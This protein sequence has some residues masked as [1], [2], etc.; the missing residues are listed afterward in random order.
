MNDVFLDLVVVLGPEA[1]IR[2]D[3]VG[4]SLPMARVQFLLEGMDS[5]R[6][7]STSPGALYA[8]AS[9]F[10]VAAGRL[11]RIQDQRAS[12]TGVP[13]PVADVLG[14]AETMSAEGE[15]LGEPVAVTSAAG[16]GEL[17]AAP[18]SD[19]QGACSCE[20]GDGTLT[21]PQEDLCSQAGGA[22]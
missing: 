22:A 10:A 2:P 12:V 15:R 7:Q 6:I 9:A 5:I 21:C 1:E 13:G 4:E 19:I 8:A 20:P 3:V 18:P 14:E 11:R 16:P 17:V